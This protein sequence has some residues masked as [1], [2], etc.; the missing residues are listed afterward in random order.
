MGGIRTAGDLVARMQMTRKM[1]LPEAKR[2]VAEKLGVSVAD[3]CDATVMRGLREELDIGVIT[4]VP[5]TAKG[6]EAKARIADLWVESESGERF[7]VYL[8]RRRQPSSARCPRAR[9]RTSSRASRRRRRRRRRWPSSPSGPRQAAPQG[10]RDRHRPLEHDAPCSAASAARRSPR[11]A[12]EIEDYSAPHFIEAAEGIKRYRGQGQPVHPGGHAQQAHPRHPPADGRRSASSRPGTGR[13]TS[14][15]S[16]SRTRW[17]PATR[18][19]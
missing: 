10:Q 18:S 1:R 7:D 6:L 9:P 4:A 3:I 8:A 11:R 17:R 16:P 13:T 15:T 5:G 19:S 14:P 12:S 2:Y